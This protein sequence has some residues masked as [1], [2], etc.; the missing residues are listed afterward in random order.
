MLATGGPGMFALHHGA[1]PNPVPGHRRREGTRMTRCYVLLPAVLG[2]AWPLVGCAARQ[3]VREEIARSE[4]GLRPALDRLASDLRA[5]QAGVRE[6]SIKMAQVERTAEEAGR[7]S[8]EALG[9]ADVA[10]G[11]TADAVDQVS[12]ASARADAARAL[13]ERALDDAERTSQRLTRLWRDRSR[14]SVVD[15]IVLR[16]GVD[17]WTLDDQARMVALDVARR[18]RENP[19]LLVQLEGYTDGVGAWPH[20]LRLSQLRAEAVVRFLVEQ[21]IEAHRLHAIGLGTVR[22]VSDNGTHEGRR[23]NRR[24]V[25]RLLDPS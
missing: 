9:Q 4:A 1:S 15:A 2:L 6:L 17:A 19:E 5:H 10:A 18:L 21:G 25:V 7:R 8:I 23:Q 20:N 11:T 24:V 3:F 14:Y 16:F 12:A 13:A 22:P